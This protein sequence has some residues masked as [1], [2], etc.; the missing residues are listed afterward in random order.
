MSPASRYI[1]VVDDERDI[2]ELLVFNLRR[3]GYE[4]SAA[5]SGREALAALERRPP[6]LVILDV[7]LPQFSGVEIARRIRTDPTLRH[8]PILMLSAKASETDQLIGLSTGADDY[9]TKPFS[10]KLLLA[11]VETILRRVAE[12]GDHTPLVLGPLRMDPGTFEARVDDRPLQ[13]TLTEFRLLWALVQAGGRV[14]KR[15]ELI[16]LAIGPGVTVTERTI[17]VHMT[18][19][20]KKLGERAG[21]IQTVRGMGYRAVTTGLNTSSQEAAR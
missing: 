20:R 13:L 17:D 2:V 18:S 5:T 7:M 10:M 3:A 4:V 15:A 19:V 16:S 11:R 14:L 6:D 1:L 8:V 9:V 21:L 12:R